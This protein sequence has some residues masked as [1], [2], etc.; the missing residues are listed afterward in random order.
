[1]SALSDFSKT[2]PQLETVDVESIPTGIE[3]GSGSTRMKL[4]E[5]APRKKNIPKGLWTKCGK[6][7]ELIYDKDLEENL[8]TC[9]SCGYH[10]RSRHGYGWHRSWTTGHSGKWM[11]G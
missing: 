7:A 4:G 6:C 11:P 3:P 8:K 2:T 9:P 1:M 5:A 10:F